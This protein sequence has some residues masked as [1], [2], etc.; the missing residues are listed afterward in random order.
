MPS[1]SAH[2][3]LPI[4][5]LH[6]D[7]AARRGQPLAADEVRLRQVARKPVS[8]RGSG[9]VPGFNCVTLSVM[10]ALIDGS[11]DRF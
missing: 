1:S 4:R 11:H 7:C 3:V 6:Y 2:S 5:F 9:P 8:E 10:A